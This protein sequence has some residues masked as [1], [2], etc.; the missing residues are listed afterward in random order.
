MTLSRPT[1]ALAAVYGRLLRGGANVIVP[2]S[3]LARPTQRRTL[4][5]AGFALHPRAV[6]LSVWSLQEVG[7]DWCEADLESVSWGKPDDVSSFID[8]CQVSSRK[9][10]RETSSSEP[11]FATRTRA[12]LCA[13]SGADRR[14]ARRLRVAQAS[15]PVTRLRALCAFRSL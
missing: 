7:G 8:R 9:E 13:W 15:V 4:H 5:D 2:A 1:A 12:L 3:A 11:R 10:T 6:E 14:V